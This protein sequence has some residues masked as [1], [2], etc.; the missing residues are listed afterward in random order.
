MHVTA[1]FAPVTYFDVTGIDVPF[2]EQHKKSGSTK[3][4]FLK[5]SDTFREF[6]A[7][8]KSDAFKKADAFKKYHLR[9]VEGVVM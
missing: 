7:F 3:S 6:E 5:K 2:I 4:E 9:E 8:R 1:S